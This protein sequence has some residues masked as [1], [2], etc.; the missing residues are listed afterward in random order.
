LDKFYQITTKSATRTLPKLFHHLNRPK[1]VKNHKRATI[2]WAEMTEKTT[3]KK[4]KQQQWRPDKALLEHLIS[5]AGSS[6]WVA[7]EVATSDHHRH[8]HPSHPTT[9]MRCTAR[10]DSLNSSSTRADHNEDPSGYAGSDRGMGVRLLDG[11]SGSCVAIRPD[12]S[13]MRCLKNLQ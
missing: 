2:E 12:E 5:A 1:V 7:N 11:C 9:R 10:R 6:T 4:K 3:A 8:Q 13:V